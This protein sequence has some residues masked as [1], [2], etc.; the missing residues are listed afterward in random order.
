MNHPMLGLQI[1]RFVL[2]LAISLLAGS[3]TW[4]TSSNETGL[5]PQWTYNKTS[6]TLNGAGFREYGF[7]KIKV[8]AAALYL[9]Q[10]ESN[11]DTILNSP[12]PKVIQ[13]KTLR[14][15]SKEDA[16]KAWNIYLQ[17][18]CQATCSLDPK[19][20]E[21]FTGLI[22]ESLAG[23]QQTYIFANNALELR[24]NGQILGIVD[25]PSFARTVLATWIGTQPSTEA[26]KRA[27]LGKDLP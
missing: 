25:H 21:A 8:Y 10:K 2:A 7:F 27:L 23:D 14:N 5:P 22:P 12:Q 17:A 9:T 13:V 26:L 15:V 20:L 4:A 24:R 3:P 1:P 16:V 6:L 11:A 18:N 19:A